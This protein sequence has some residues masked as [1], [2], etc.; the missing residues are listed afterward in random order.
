MIPVTAF[1]ANETTTERAMIARPLIILSLCCFLAPAPASPQ[2]KLHG[3]GMAGNARGKEARAL[4]RLKNRYNR[5][6]PEDYSHYGITLEAM[7]AKGDDEKRF[8]NSQAADVE[9]YVRDVTIG[10]V[11]SCNC[12][13]T[14]ARWRDTH[15]VLVLDSKD[16]SARRSVIAE[17]TPR[18]RE[19]VAKRGDDWSTDALKK[20]LKGKRVRIRGWMLYDHHY[21]DESENT[22]PG[23]KK[24]WR[25]TAWEIHPVIS[26]EVLKKK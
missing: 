21:E 7:L 5:P 22:H 26:I 25:A 12:D 9:G 11:E 24:N 8:T 17:V 13:A 23:G 15:I 20:T 6:M 14:D 4:N 18:W 2:E 10:G 16:N 19:E 1:R 3:C